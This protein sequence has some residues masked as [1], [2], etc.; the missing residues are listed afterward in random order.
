MSHGGDDHSQRRS[1]SLD[2]RDAERVRQHGIPQRCSQCSSYDGNAPCAC[3]AG[4]GS[5]DQR[6]AYRRPLKVAP[7][8]RGIYLGAYDCGAKG[9]RKP[10]VMEFERATGSKVALTG[11][12]FCVSDEGQPFSINAASLKKLN[13]KGYVVLID[14]TPRRY[15]PQQSSKGQ[16]DDTLR[17]AA[18]AI[19]LPAC[20]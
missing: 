11:A 1:L 5:G 14:V 17:E 2:V 19:K 9:N 16:A 4:R 15:L 12:G 13:E 10:G 7:P 18:E 6:S 8:P 20:R 3:G